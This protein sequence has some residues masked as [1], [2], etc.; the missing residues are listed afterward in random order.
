MI[1][2]DNK[3][4]KYSLTYS[5]IPTVATNKWNTRPSSIILIKMVLPVIKKIQRNMWFPRVP[6]VTLHLM[7]RSLFLV[8]CRGLLLGFIIL[9]PVPSMGVVNELSRELAG[10]IPNFVCCQRVDISLVVSKLSVFPQLYCPLSSFSCRV[11][12]LL[13]LISTMKRG[14]LNMN[15]WKLF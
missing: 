10:D 11:Q 3:F 12:R 6:S 7:A 15:F 13:S 1:N 2:S 4:H 5:I 8:F 14:S 9:F